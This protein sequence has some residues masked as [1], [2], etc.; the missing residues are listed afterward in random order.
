MRGREVDEIRH[1]RTKKRRRQTSVEADGQHALPCRGDVSSDGI[2]LHLPSS[3][4][5]RPHMKRH[6]QSWERKTE[7]VELEHMEPC[8]SGWKRSKSTSER[9]RE[10]DKENRERRVRR[11]RSKTQGFLRGMIDWR[12]KMAV[13]QTWSC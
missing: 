2:L 11:I 10:K 4:K 7:E 13:I 9:E 1:E 6:S 8:I 5:M 3:N 12:I